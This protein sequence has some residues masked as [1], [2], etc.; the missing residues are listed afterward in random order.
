MKLISR[1]LKGF[2]QYEYLT[3]NSYLS[4]PALIL[5]IPPPLSAQRHLPHASPWAHQLYT[6]RDPWL[7]SELVWNTG[8]MVV[9]VV[10][11]LH[12]VE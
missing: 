8:I 5:P 4:A 12:K 10:E 6:V 9:L 11:L 2:V 3:G 7:R 1:D